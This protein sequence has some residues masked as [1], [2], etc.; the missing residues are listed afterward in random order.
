LAEH[1]E[2][3]QHLQTPICLD[4]S[5]DSLEAIRKIIELKA[6]RIL[7][8]KV[9]RMGGLWLAKQAHD[10]AQSAGLPCWLGTM[11]E[12]GI[13]SAQGLHL[14]TLSGFTFP[15]DVEASARW[16]VDDIISPAIELAADGTI[17]V[18]DA[19]GMGYSVNLEKVARYRI[20]S[21]EFQV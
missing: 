5:A 9:Q 13:A 7:N 2:L 14:A 1:A 12:L 4:E 18:P 8:I 3:Q 10:L 15:T 16:Y 20:L 19:P 21:E 17:S 6:G 11:P